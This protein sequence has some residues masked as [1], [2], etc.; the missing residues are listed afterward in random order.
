MRGAL[1]V[2][3]MA[4]LLCALTGR[5]E[6][7]TKQ[8]VA[9]RYSVYPRKTVFLPGTWDMTM[10]QRKKVREIQNFL[11][12]R[13][14]AIVPTN[15][16]AAAELS[17]W[18]D[19]MDTTFL[20]VRPDPSGKWGS[21]CQW[22]SGGLP[23]MST[24]WW[25]KEVAIYESYWSNTIEF[26]LNPIS[27]PKKAD[28]DAQ[29]ANVASSFVHEMRHVNGED[30]FGAYSYEWKMFKALGIDKTNARY[31]K[32]RSQ[33]ANVVKAYYD[34]PNDRWLRKAPSVSSAPACMSP[35]RR[36]K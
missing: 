16:A 29:F 26:H 9:P 2:L 30:E 8:Y 36:Y 6:A 1:I 11:I 7:Q 14:N 24:S 34:A 20:R 3:T 13:A 33:L 31:A 21:F 12:D 22:Y 17:A 32:V 28:L 15:A 35:L 5:L 25:Y 19:Q 27:H 18:A 10:E 4:A 23:E